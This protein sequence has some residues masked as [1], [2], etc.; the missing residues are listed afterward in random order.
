MA[1]RRP[2]HE[3]IV[4]AIR[5]IPVY[6]LPILADLICETTIP[7]GHDE[8]IAA[9]KE[10]MNGMLDEG[11]FGIDVVASLMEQKRESENPPEM[12]HEE[13]VKEAL[14]RR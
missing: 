9:W 14:D 10:K 2:F 4:D 5:R 1:E 13:K 3:T 7:K 12:T 6:N 11:G 8:I